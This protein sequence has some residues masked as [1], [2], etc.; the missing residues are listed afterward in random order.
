MPVDTAL[1]QQTSI[2]DIFRVQGGYG[3]LF[4]RIPHPDPSRGS[5]GSGESHEY[6]STRLGPWLCI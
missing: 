3:R 2:H 4:Q 5:F 6:N 1:D